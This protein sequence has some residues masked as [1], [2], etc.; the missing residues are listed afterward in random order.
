MN[1][2]GWQDGTIKHDIKETIE[3][4]LKNDHIR[5]KL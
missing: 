3:M 4:V 1:A 5:G 2:S